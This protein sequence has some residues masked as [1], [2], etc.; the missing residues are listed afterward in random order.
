M[1]SNRNI[2]EQVHYLRQATQSLRKGF[3]CLYCHCA[4]SKITLLLTAHYEAQRMKM[5]TE[6]K[7][8][9]DFKKIDRLAKF[10]EIRSLNLGYCIAAYSCHFTDRHY[11]LATHIG[12][13]SW[14]LGN[15]K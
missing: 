7:P 5:T 6:S 8:G 2:N 11:L 4:R 9:F 13:S 14:G 15:K 12:H 3:W 10:L 1:G